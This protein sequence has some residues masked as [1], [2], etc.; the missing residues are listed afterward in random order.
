MQLQSINN[1]AQKHFNWVESKNWHKK[2]PLESIALIG[3]EIGEELAEAFDGNHDKLK[4]EV[5]DIF[6]R[7]ID[8]A[9][10]HKLD[11][12]HLRNENIQ[13]L[14]NLDYSKFGDSIIENI[15]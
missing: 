13:I 2:T 8:L 12:D 15:A 4:L 5:A 10:E 9:V 1:I 6:L 3:S 7:T 11:L 14:N